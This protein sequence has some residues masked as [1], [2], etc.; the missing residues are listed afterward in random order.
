MDKYIVAEVY[1]GVIFSWELAEKVIYEASEFYGSDIKISYI[2]N[3][4][5]SY[6][7]IPRDWLN[8]FREFSKNVVSTAFV[9][10]SGLGIKNY[11]VEK[12]FIRGK[13]GHFTH[14][15]EAVEWTVYQHKK[16]NVENPT[17]A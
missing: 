11:L 1:E 4:I 8:L 17:N 12:I 5:N 15:M 7:T 14:L 3:R 16:L 13:V 9:N 2:T 6:S 10:Y